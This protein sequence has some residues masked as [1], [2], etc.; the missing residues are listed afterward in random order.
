MTG[1]NR[2]FSKKKALEKQISVLKFGDFDR[3]AYIWVLEIREKSGLQEGSSLDI[4]L[5]K[6]VVA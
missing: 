4:I 6:R 3:V 1:L 2:V 5:E